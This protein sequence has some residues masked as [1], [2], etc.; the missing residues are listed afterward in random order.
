MFTAASAVSNKLSISNRS[1][2]AWAHC[3]LALVCVASSVHLTTNYRLPKQDY[4]SARQ[5][6][7]ANRSPTDPVWT[8]GMAAKPLVDYYAPT[9]IE[10]E[11]AEELD[12]AAAA[13]PE[14]WLVYSFDKALKAMHPDVHALIEAK[15]E[16]VATF[17]GTLGGGAVHVCRR[18]LKTAGP[19]GC[20]RGWESPSRSAA[21]FY[22]LETRS[23][24]AFGLCYH[25]PLGALFGCWLGALLLRFDGPPAMARR[26]R[27]RADA[28]RALGSD[29]ARMAS[30][31]PRNPGG[32]PGSA[33]SLAVVRLRR[34]RDLGPVV[35]HQVVLRP[36]P[37]DGRLGG[38]GRRRTGMAGS[39]AGSL[40]RG[41]ETPT[42]PSVG[43]VGHQDLQ[44]LRAEV[45]RSRS[46]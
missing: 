38:A 29:P 22:I 11:T 15:F 6:V 36:A 7:E 14:A 28:R 18:P 24:P 16:V 30:V 23:R 12:A 25:V 13:N 27:H 17:P 5:Y 26:R 20:A 43:E 4:A 40:K 35:G 42:L 37:D 45:T 31:G 46:T 9:W 44:P 8:T 41:G 33:R 3:A 19:R 39:P 21:R 10:H 1:G 34:R 2:A 32:L